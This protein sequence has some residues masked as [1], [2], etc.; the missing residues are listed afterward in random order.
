M[1]K[2]GNT[3]LT[4]NYQRLNDATIIPV[5]PLPSID[6]LLDS[7]GGSKVFSVLDL[8]SGFFQAAIEPDSIPLTAACTQTGLYERLRMPMGASGSPGCFQ[9]LMA[10]V[11]EGLQRVQLH[12]DDIVVHSKSASHHAVDLRG[13]LALLTE[14]NLK[15]SPK[16][17]HIGAPEVQFLGHLVTPSGLRPDPKKIKAML[18]MPMPSTKGELRSLLGSLSYLRK[19][20]LSLSTT[21]K[22][23]HSLLH[24]DVRLEFTAHY[25]AVANKVLKQLV[26]SGVLAFPDYQ[27]AIDDSRK[28]QLVTD[29]SKEGFGASLERKQPDGKI[30]SLYIRRTTL[31]SEKNWDTSELECD[32]LVWAAIKK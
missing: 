6:E 32:A 3:R 2:D 18:K 21:V 19:F 20:L 16:K 17:A 15:L 26:S 23:L 30:R 27:A 8:A 5:L 11:C 14:Y 31:P 28:F 29:A 13:F 7:L 22:D 4:C 24:K 9:R 12:I 10:Q 25:T 1:K